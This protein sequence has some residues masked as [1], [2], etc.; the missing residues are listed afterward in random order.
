MIQRLASLLFLLLVAAPAFAHKPSDSYLRLTVDGATIAGEWALSL[1]DLARLITIDANDDQTITWGELRVQ[2]P[3]IAAILAEDLTFIVAE[4]PCPITAGDLMVEELSDGNYAVMRFTASCTTA[5]ET[6]TL[7]D[8][9]FY[10]ADAQHKNL[11]SINA[12]DYT[13][14][15][16]L[17]HDRRTAV[18]SMRAP[19]ALKQLYDYARQ[20]TL[21]IWLGLDHFLFLLALLLPA[22]WIYR[23]K[24]PVLDAPFN[25]VFWQVFGYVSAFTLAHAATLTLALFNLIQLPSRLVESLIALTI[26]VACINN[27]RP[28]LTQRLWLLTFVFGLIH[29]MGFASTLGDLGLAVEARWLALLGFNLGVEFGQLVVVTILLPIFY[30]IRQHAAYRWLVVRG[31]SGVILIL[32]TIWLIQRSSGVMIWQFLGP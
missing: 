21:H 12:P 7:R 10:D 9:F 30:T 15:T 16:I 8:N 25:Q 6:L 3:A 14:S 31:F 24:K 27:M 20:G 28:F 22:A 18:L 19:S 29:G 11:V 26:I 13:Q 2:H 17:S 32:A 23:D 1:R 4:Q 5:I